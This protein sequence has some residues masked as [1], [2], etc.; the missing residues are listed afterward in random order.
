MYKLTFIIILSVI[1]FSSCKKSCYTCLGGLYYTPIKY[2]SSF[3]I[4][5]DSAF[6]HYDT[7]LVKVDT[8]R[9]LI[10]TEIHHVC[11]GNP[12]YIQIEKNNS[13]GW[14]CGLDQ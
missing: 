2:D 11:P 1:L 7:L 8:I 10:N 4:F 14:S 5:Y 13:G 12:D 6:H 9:R 3:N